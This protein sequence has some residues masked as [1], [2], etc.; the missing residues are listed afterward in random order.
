MA[1]AQHGGSVGRPGRI[2]DRDSCGVGVARPKQGDGDHQRHKSECP[3]DNEGDAPRA[4]SR[5]AR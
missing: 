1:I 2:A 3:D 5:S 4:R